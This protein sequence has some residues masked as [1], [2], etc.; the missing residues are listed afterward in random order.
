MKKYN[1]FTINS[2]QTI[3]DAL[4]SIKL[5]G[6]KT[7]IVLEKKKVIG[8]VDVEDIID[9][10]IKKIDFTISVKQIMNKSFKFMLDDNKKDAIYLF[11]KF[12]IIIIPIVD[13][14][15]NLKKIIHFKNFI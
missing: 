4:V 12:N 9:A 2:N 7:V 6:I 11:K 1:I 14:K 15:M 10:I 5:N 13:K 3:Y 8:V